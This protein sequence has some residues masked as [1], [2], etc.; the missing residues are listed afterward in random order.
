MPYIHP[1]F[2]SREYKYWYG[3][4]VHTRDGYEYGYPLL[5]GNM[6]TNTIRSW[7]EPY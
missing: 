4:G 1:Y 2:R 7:Y 5:Q 3:M 6:K